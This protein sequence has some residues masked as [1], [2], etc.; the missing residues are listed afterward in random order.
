M[1][2]IKNSHFGLDM[3]K[4]INSVPLIVRTKMMT[5]KK[6]SFSKEIAES[7]IGTFEL[8]IKTVEG[9]NQTSITVDQLKHLKKVMQKKYY[10]KKVILQ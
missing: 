3:K 2:E 9:T 10:N 7:V 8:I 4:M 1:V 5:D 6:I